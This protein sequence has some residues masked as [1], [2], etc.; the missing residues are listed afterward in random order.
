[1]DS[2]L[3]EMDKLDIERAGLIATG[4]LFETLFVSIEN[5]CGPLDEHDVLKV[6]RQYPDRFFGYVYVRP[7]FD[8][9]EKV[10]RWGELGFKG[11]KFHIPEQ[12]YGHYDYLPIYE[13]AQ[14]LDMV[15]L[16]HTGLFYFRP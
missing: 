2:L 9:P 4:P 15:C 11:V 16:F 3:K 7:G 6:M 12:N 1:M 5:T 8:G 13:T 14:E 10:R